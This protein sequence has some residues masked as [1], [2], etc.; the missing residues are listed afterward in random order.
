[1][2]KT[3]I[4]MMAL[5]TVTIGMTQEDKS[6]NDQEFKTIFNANKGDNKIIHGG[7][8]G[9][10]MNYTQIDNKDAF[11]A[12]IRGMWII[13]HGIGIGI[14]GYGFANE[15]RFDQN[16]NNDQDYYLAG[17]YG[18]LTIEPIIMAKQPVHVS[19]PVLIGAG[20]VALINDYNWST[21]YPDHNNDYYSEDAEAFFVVE[22]GIEVEFN[23]V[24]FFRLAIGGYYR[25]TSNVNL[26]QWD[27]PEKTISPDLS[28]FSVGMTLKFGKF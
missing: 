18:G 11:L 28:G 1:M 9:I 16:S 7:Y 15:L 12:G 20:G 6:K 22:P 5:L 17:G 8:G 13:N 25:F 10:M 4:L 24:K 14:G 3:V 2:K 27:N 21:N 23:M 26:Y 19:F